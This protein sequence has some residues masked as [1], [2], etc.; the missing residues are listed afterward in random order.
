MRRETILELRKQKSV[1]E[2]AQEKG[3]TTQYIYQILSGYKPP[4]KNPLTLKIWSRRKRVALGLPD[5]KIPFKGGGRDYMRELVRIRDGRQCTL[6]GHKW[7]QGERRLDVH[8]ED[9]NEEGRS[10]ERNIVNRDKATL[11]RMTTL[12]HPCHMNLHVVVGKMKGHKRK[13][14]SKVE[15]EM[16]LDLWKVGTL[17]KDIA[18]KFGVTIMSINKRIVKYK[19]SL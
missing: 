19:N 2:I 1:R 8:H 18:K 9:P 17:Q 5:E 3:V 6:C 14:L 7:K 4:L 12:C 15:G 16:V 13:V 10:K 11:K